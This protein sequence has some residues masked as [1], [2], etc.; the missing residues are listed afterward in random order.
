M[1]ATY[2]ETLRKRRGHKFLPNKS[3]GIPALG[4]TERIADPMVCAHYFVGSWDWYV[5]EYDPTTGD[6]FGLVKGF[7][8]ELGYFNLFELETVLAGG[9]WPVERDCYFDPAPLSTFR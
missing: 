1:T 6:A 9:L 4:T 7:E 3:G 8:T 2:T 5:T